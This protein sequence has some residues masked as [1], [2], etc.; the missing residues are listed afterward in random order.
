MANR[1]LQS[2]SDESKASTLSRCLRADIELTNQL[3]DLLDRERNETVVSQLPPDTSSHNILS[4]VL[5]PGSLT[6]TTSS[7]ATFNQ[8]QRL[9]SAIGYRCIGFGQCGLVFERPGRAYVV[10]LA[11]PGYKE[12]LLA[13][14]KAHFFVKNAFLRQTSAEC[15][16]PK[17]CAWVTDSNIEWW[18][19]NLFLFPTLP[20]PIPLPTSTL[21]TER[22]LPLPKVARQAL[23][24]R[25]CP[26]HLKAAVSV[27]PKNRDCLA[28]LYLGSRRSNP[29]LL[30]PN[31][32][33]RNFNLHLDQMLELNLPVSLYAHAIGEALATIHWGAC[34]DGYDI[35]FV[36]GGEGN[37]GTSC[38]E[39]VTHS[40][41]LTEEQVCNMTSNDEMDSAVRT[42]FKQRATHIWVL[43]FN[44][45]SFWRREIGYEDPDALISHLVQAFFQNDPYYP[46]PHCNDGNDQ[47]LWSTFSVSYRQKGNEILGEDERLVDLPGRFIDACVSYDQ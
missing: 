45:C 8:S 16:V 13:D 1:R 18:N 14:F 46:R 24:D 21:V 25:Y 20:Q 36:L 43:D 28:R 35:E 47:S 42:N 34:V 33:L 19:E 31:F 6:S 9:N 29:D 38:N 4:R 17:L 39:N 26:P 30:S 41:Q 37:A 15:C 12:A 27:D 22:I 2:S 3:S 32:T 11:N 5:S 40:L 44:L 7:F 10:K 23:I